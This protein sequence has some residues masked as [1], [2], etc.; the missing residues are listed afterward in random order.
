MIW[1]I[2]SETG[3]RSEKPYSGGRLCVNGCEDFLIGSGMCWAGAMRL[4]SFW[5]AG[6]TPP[7]A[8]STAANTFLIE[9]VMYL[10]LGHASEELTEALREQA[11]RFL[12]ENS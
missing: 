6:K 9:G 11:G 2:L 7:S 1:N 12:H 4:A 3:N 10:T 5:R 8:M